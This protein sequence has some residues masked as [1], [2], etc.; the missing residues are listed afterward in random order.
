MSRFLLRDM[1][2]LLHAT[3]PA[4]LGYVTPQAY[5]PKGPLLPRSRFFTDTGITMLSLMELQCTGIPRPLETVHGCM[6]A[7]MHVCM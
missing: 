7:C 1:P 4:P 5:P 6:H 2:P 3:C